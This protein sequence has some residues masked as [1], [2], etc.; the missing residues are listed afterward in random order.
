MEQ[1]Q[2]FEIEA[3]TAARVELEENLRTELITFMAEAVIAVYRTESE[4][5]DDSVKSENSP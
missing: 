4:V 5:R 2:L 1:L 3:G